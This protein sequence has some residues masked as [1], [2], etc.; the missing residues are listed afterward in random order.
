MDGIDGW[1]DDLNIGWMDGMEC[2]TINYEMVLYMYIR[3]TRFYL[4]LLE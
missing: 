3:W 2:F 4:E 1:M